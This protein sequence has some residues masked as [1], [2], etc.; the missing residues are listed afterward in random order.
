[1]FYLTEDS[2]LVT[3]DCIPSG[4]VTPCMYTPISFYRM[5]YAQTAMQAAYHVHGDVHGDVHIKALP[6]C[7]HHCED[8]MG[9]EFASDYHNPWGFDDEGEELLF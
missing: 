5:R 3:I 4:E 1:M 8:E 6:S 9:A 2:V 7:V